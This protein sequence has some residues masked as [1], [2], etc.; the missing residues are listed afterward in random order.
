MDRRASLKAIF[1]FVAI[2]RE[3]RF[4][5]SGH[6][7]VL[8]AQYYSDRSGAVRYKESAQPLWR[9]CSAIKI[10]GKAM[11]LR[12]SQ[13][14]VVRWIN[15]CLQIAIFTFCILPVVAQTPAPPPTRQDNV[16]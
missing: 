14:R 16:K 3:R 1:S 2:G 4:R 13:S 12:Q 5:F 8:H 10:E 15:R 6:P 9:E 11:N 7:G